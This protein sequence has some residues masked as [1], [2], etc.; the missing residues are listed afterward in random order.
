MDKSM[1]RTFS[2]LGN[3]VGVRQSGG[4]ISMYVRAMDDAKSMKMGID[5]NLNRQETGNMTMNLT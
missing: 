4:L 1:N 5:P 3:Q 2:K